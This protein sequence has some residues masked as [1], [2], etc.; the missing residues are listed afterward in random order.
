MRGD[1]TPFAERRSSFLEAFR[2]SPF[3]RLV[4]ETSMT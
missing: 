3:Q 1:S 2:R 4:P